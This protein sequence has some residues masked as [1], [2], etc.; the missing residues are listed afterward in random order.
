MR[1]SQLRKCSRARNALAA[2][3]STFNFMKELPMF[4]TLVAVSSGLAPSR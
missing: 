2:A 4:A 3:K 1:C